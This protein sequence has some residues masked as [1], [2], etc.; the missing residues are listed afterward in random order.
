MLLVV[1][2]LFAV[3]HL[4]AQPQHFRFERTDGNMS[5]LILSATLDGASLVQGDEIGFFTED[6]LCAGASVVVENFPD[7]PTG[8]AAWGAE[9]QMDNGLQNQEPIEF[10]VWDQDEDSEVIVDEIE[11]IAGRLVYVINTMLRVRLTAVTGPDEPNIVIDELEHDFGVVR[12]NR[13]SEWELVI[14]NDGRTDLIISAMDIDEGPFS[15]NF[16]EEDT[17]GTRDE[18]S[19]IVTFAP[20]EEGDAEA[21]LT[22]TSND[23]T[24]GEGE[25]EISLT[26]RAEPALPPTIELSRNNLPFGEIVVGADRL[27]L[28][29]ISNLGDETLVVDEVTL[30][31]DVFTTNFETDFEGEIRVA[32]EDSVNLEVLFAP[33]EEDV[34]VADM[35]IHCNDPEL[36]NGEISVHLTGEG[37]GEQQPPAIAFEAADSS[38][39]FGYVLSNQVR[40]WRFPILNAGVSDLM[41][42]GIEI[43]EEHFTTDF[44]DDEVRIRRGDRW[45]VDV[46]FQPVDFDFYDA[47]MTIFSNDPDS[48]EYHIALAGRC[49]ADNGRHFQWYGTA[50]SHVLLV[51]VT[52]LDADTLVGGDEVGIFTTSGLCAGGGVVANDGRAGLVA[53][54]D[55]SVS[56]LIL[57]GFNDGEEFRFMVWDADQ[58]VE[59][60]AVPEWDQGSQVFRANGFSRLSLSAVTGEPDPDIYVHRTRRYFGQV[61]IEGGSADW[62]FTIQNQGLGDLTISSIESD[63]E[64]YTT[65]FQSETTIEGRGSLD[66]TVTFRPIQERQYNG[67]LTINSDDPDEEVFYID[68][69]G[70]G[71]INPENPGITLAENHFFGVASI[72]EEVTYILEIESSGG[73]PLEIEELIPEGD[74]AF[75]TNWGGQSQIIQPG[76][77][78]NIVFTFAPDE[79]REFNAVFTLMTNVVGE[80]EYPFPVRGYGL[81]SDDYFQNLNTGITHEITVSSATIRT[82]QDHELSLYPG[83]EIGVFTPAGLCVGHVV[84]EEAGVAVGLTAYAVNPDNE[85]RDGF[86]NGGEFTF[87]F[88]DVST[89]DVLICDVEFV[90]GQ[91]AFQNGGETNVNLSAVAETQEP[92]LW[93][94]PILEVPDMGSFAV[95]DFGPVRVNDRVEGAFNFHNIGGANLVIEGIQSNRPVFVAVFNEQILIEPGESVEVAVTFSPR[96]AIA[97]EGTLTVASNDPHVEGYE[98]HPVGLGSASV[99]HFV[100]GRSGSNHSLLITE[101]DI[102]G[103]SPGIGDEFGLFTESDR[104]AGV[105]IVVNPEID[106]GLAAWG[107]DND[108]NF[109]VEGFLQDEVISIK[110]YDASQ[111]REYSGDDLIIE[112]SEGDL[113]WANNAFTR[114]TIAVEGIVSIIPVPPIAVDED[115]LVGFDLVLTNPEGDWEFTWHNGDPEQD[116]PNTDVADFTVE[117]NVGSFSWQTGFDD[118]D[119]YELRF[120]ATDG[121]MVDYIG[122]IVD[123]GDVNRAPV[124]VQEVADGAF[125]D[126]VYTIGEDAGMTVVVN[127]NELFTDLDGDNLQFWYNDRLQNVTQRLADGVY[128]IQPAPEFSGVI[129]GAYLV[130]DD[131]QNRVALHLRA[132]RNVEQRVEI[133]TLG[134]ASR[135]VRRIDRQ[136]TPHRDDT[137]QFDFTINVTP[138]NDVPVIRQPEDADVHV[139]QVIEGQELSVNFSAED[140]EDAPEDLVWIIADP[141][142]LPDEGPDFNDNDGDGT[143]TFTWTPDFDVAQMQQPFIPLF[144]VTDTDQDDPQSDQITLSITVLDFN[145]PPVVVQPIEDQEWVEDMDRA[146]IADLNQVFSDPDP[147]EVLNFIIREASDSLQI[148]LDD[149]NIL[150]GQP[151]ADFNTW[152]MIEGMLDSLMVIVAVVDDDGEAELDTFYVKVAPVNDAPQAFSMLTPED[153]TEIPYADSLGTLDFTWQAS[154][155][156]QWELDSV[157]YI[158][159]FR[160]QGEVDS[161]TTDLLDDISY[162]DIPIQDIADSLG[163]ERGVDL[164]IE[165]TVYAVDSEVAVMAVNAPFSF[166]IPALS[167][168]DYWDAGIPDDF[169]LS[170][171]FPNPF[172]SETTVR[173]GLPNM[174]KV[175]ITV[176]DMHGRRVATL[177][178]RQM[179][180]GRYASTWNAS[181]LT[182]G[183]Y[184]IRMQSGDFTSMK[185]AILIR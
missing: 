37:L 31:S 131:G 101:M 178:D 76:Q 111:D 33:D 124:V 162:L 57:D 123:V 94:D 147:D 151:I 125:P 43:D 88:W 169:F 137:T 48:A 6:G 108:T 134:V 129:E 109:L 154:R 115:D 78:Y 152:N 146:Q 170:P 66:V 135:S 161:V 149:E 166:K 164:W 35:V 148:E 91:E 52:T 95:I 163:W 139:V 22:V 83:D 179:T 126:G 167:V 143:W 165:W 106:L 107:D 14:G 172:N 180:A 29:T 27:M 128:S 68:V 104:C 46:M 119:H 41:V 74:E 145:R 45:Y 18:V 54:G 118:A 40:T 26:G 7:S 113:T 56:E 92:L 55:D 136:L 24:E 49:G 51:D 79:A 42:S 8:G 99:G 63:F 97:Y 93:I 11:I 176:W 85:Y 62:V 5:I 150:S 67:R 13:S 142:G 9:D 87:K 58:D 81:D 16:E 112:I 100:T 158:V 121:E 181:G 84:I 174:A 103:A 10:R 102:G 50:D 184:L 171:S 12:L 133:A 138:V 44:G 25:I 144:R 38:H 185:K 127:C 77:F 71:V 117:N 156:V 73:A 182:S 80:E 141:D 157:R 4:F 32:A 61:S 153:G 64:E 105:S 21:T 2:F 19:Y 30:E 53:W 159:A 23:P 70:E 114:L 130:A 36:E 155:Q 120:S 132:V 15:V 3:P 17:V 34:F 20:E 183:I 177:A 75:T 175:S 59:A 60:E 39:F 110:F 47:T 86:M 65:D 72:G 140:I 28:L 122:V 69:I 90:G 98:A 89:E 160:I 82:L 168:D 116:Y 96:A 1:L 173:F